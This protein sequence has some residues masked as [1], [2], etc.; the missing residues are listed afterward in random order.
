MENRIKNSSWPACGPH[1]VEPDKSESTAIVFVGV[2]LRDRRD[3]A[4]GGSAGDESDGGTDLYPV[5][6]LLKIGVQVRVTTS[7]VWLSFSESYPYTA[8]AQTR[9]ETLGIRFIGLPRL[10]QSVLQELAIRLPQEKQ[11]SLR[12]PL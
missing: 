6:K 5:R 3:L 10:Q 4:K 7:G 12:L 8:L 2:R 9:P 11:N 1:V